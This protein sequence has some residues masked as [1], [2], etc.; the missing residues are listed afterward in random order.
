MPSIP[1]LREQPRS[2]G[3]I[4]TITYHSWIV[5]FCLC[6]WAGFAFF[7]IT[8]DQLSSRDLHGLCASGIFAL[9]VAAVLYEKDSFTLN[10][11]TRTITWRTGRIWGAKSGTLSFDDVETVC[12]E[13]LD[14]PTKGPPTYRLMLK[15]QGHDLPLTN[16]YLPDRDALDKLCV[17]ISG[18]IKDNASPAQ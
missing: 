11:D 1:R 3:S 2:A 15:C 16:C 4:Y 14:I 7:K 5:A 18:I 6:C 8:F 13:P 17:A 10:K 9:A 12:A